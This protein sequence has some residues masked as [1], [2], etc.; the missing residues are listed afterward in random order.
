MQG[1]GA[2]ESLGYDKDRT[3]PLVEYLPRRHRGVGE[4]QAIHDL[5]ANRIALREIWCHDQNTDS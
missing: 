1:I 4:I 2:S 5:L 3:R